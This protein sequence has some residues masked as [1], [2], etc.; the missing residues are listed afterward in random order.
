LGGIILGEIQASEFYDIFKSRISVDF[1]VE[2][3][4]QKVGVVNQ[5]TMLASET[6]EISDYF[7][8][9]M[10]TKYGAENHKDHFSDTGDTLCYATNDNQEAT[11]ELLKQDA[12]FAIVVGGYNS[13]NTSHIVELLKTKFPTYFVNSS[14]ELI[15]A[16]EIR[17]FDI[18][19]NNMGLTQNYLPAREQTR[20][21][22]TSGASCPDILLDQV[23]M[24]LISF[25][26]RHQSL[27]KTLKK[28]N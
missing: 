20:I 14:D 3:D 22:I 26:P 21:I 5:T 7:R 27:E 16:N 25:F 13:S 11:L 12:D 4:L 9:V 23:L 17:H 6:Q 2:N 19:A 10:I 24:K 15:S 1:S 18:S 8:Q 28:F